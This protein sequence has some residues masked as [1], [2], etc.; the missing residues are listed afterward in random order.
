MKAKLEAS[1]YLTWKACDNFGRSG[2]RNVEL[3]IINKI[4]SSENAVSIV[5]DAM[6]VVGVAS[7]TKRARLGQLL[8][9]ALA[10]PLFDGGNVGVRRVQLQ[11]LLASEGY[12]PL[13]AATS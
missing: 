10:Y 1:R 13:A 11:R 7:Y 2:G 5:Y 9:D 4:Y 8:N 3:S 12:D 6:R